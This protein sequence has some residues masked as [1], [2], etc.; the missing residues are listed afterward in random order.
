M[1]KKVFMFVSVLAILILAG[2][3]N[4]TSTTSTDSS[5]TNSNQQSPTATSTPNTQA[6]LNECLSGCATLGDTGI[7]TKSLCNDTCYSTEAKAKNDITLCDKN[8]SKD[9][10]LIMAS[11]KNDVAISSGKPEYCDSLGDTPSDLFRATCYMNYAKEKKDAA[12]CEKL[13]DTLY[14]Q[15]CLDDAK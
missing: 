9:D 13:K 11:C 2:C 5:N 8:I 3:N 1:H 14:Y 6:D 7:I 10:T 4:K 15:G 12:V